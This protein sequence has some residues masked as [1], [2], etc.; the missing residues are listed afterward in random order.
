MEETRVCAP[1]SRHPGTCI[2][3]V[4]ARCQVRDAGYWR[5]G[6]TQDAVPCQVGPCLPRGES[7]CQPLWSTSRAHQVR[8]VLDP[9]NYL[10]P[11][12]GICLLFEGD[13]LQSLPVF[14]DKDPHWAGYTRVMF[15]WENPA[16]ECWF[17]YGVIMDEI[18]RQS[19][20]SHVQM[21]HR[22]RLSK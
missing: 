4:V 7:F 17:H 1:R 13:P 19:D 21:L 3:I 20:A 15:L 12:G 10:R 2:I 22:I 14:D 18:V 5:V 6:R 9:A 16:Y 11:F 8:S